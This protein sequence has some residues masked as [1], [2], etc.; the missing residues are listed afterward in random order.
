[1]EAGDVL[2]CPHRL[3]ATVFQLSPGHNGFGGDS[4]LFLFFFELATIGFSF[5]LRE[6]GRV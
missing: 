3:A 1:M 2:S 5:L 4:F 6:C